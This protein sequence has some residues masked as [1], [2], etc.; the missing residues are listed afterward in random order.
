LIGASI[1]SPAYAQR[2]DD[3]AIKSAE[4]AFGATIGNESIGIY[5]EEDVRGFSTTIAGNVRIDGLY[6]DEQ[7]SPS[8]H[9]IEGATIRVGLAAQGFAFP[10]PT[11]I[12][13]YALRR[14]TGARTLSVGVNAS[15]WGAAI[16]EID[17]QAPVGQHLAVG[18]GGSLMQ[19]IFADRTPGDTVIGSAIA[20]WRPTST[21]ELTPFYEHQ[22]LLYNPA[23]AIYLTADGSAPASLPR[24]YH[25]PDW[26]AYRGHN[27]NL[28]FTG[29]A[30]LG[31]DTTVRV[32]LFRS[33]N[34]AQTY[35]TAL[36][37]DL[38]PDGTAERL[39][40]AAPRL[41]YASTSGEARLARGI[42]EGPRHH[43]LIAAARM[44]LADSRYGGEDMVDYGRT[45]IDADGP[46]NEPAFA[47]GQ[48]TEDHVRQWSI[49]LGYSL[50]WEELGS[51]SIGLLHTNY[52]KNTS[53][54]PGQSSTSR[55]A[56]WVPSGAL[57]IS[58]TPKLALYASYTEG[59]EESG[60]APSVAVNRG[61]L[62]PAIR[63]SQRDAGFRW[64]FAWNLSLVAG[65]FDLHKPYDA[66]DTEGR[67]R[68]LGSLSS[69]GIEVSLTG[70]AAPGLTLVA[71]AVWRDARVAGE[72]VDTGAIGL[73]P[74][75]STAF[76]STA[77][78][79]YAFPHSRWSVDATL[80][81]R[82]PLVATNDDQ[83]LP[84]RGT[85]DLGMRYHLK[86]AGGDSVLRIALTNVLGEGG[87]VVLG[88]GAYKAEDDRRL[89]VSVTTDFIGV[90]H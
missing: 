50:E 45:R 82:A 83:T 71:G 62:T 44:R 18:I 25:G 30:S 9:L 65:V 86:L 4:D 66:I 47:F 78:I 64:K 85:V 52:T 84:A 14:P 79:D 16:L 90:K 11:G 37:V 61:A 46:A 81:W 51:L 35:F 67:F 40:I 13:D 31:R 70:Q 12:V 10:A 8:A 26:D 33:V 32:G 53:S 57:S 49:G 19:D 38:L 36:F 27:E 17:A 2:A 68:R 5:D 63:S 29:T 76:K 56:L 41:V 42:A 59:L 20:R 75:G 89:F 6:F 3:N 73:R 88:P 15:S 60:Q 43:L 54:A 22:Q 74:V 7:A 87:Y 77:A 1:A 28:G 24:T 72:E 55:S 69:R 58:V 34:I 21:I 48:Q 39:I 23:T 80:N